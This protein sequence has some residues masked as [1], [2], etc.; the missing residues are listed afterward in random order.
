MAVIKPNYRQ[1]KKQ[2]ELARKTRQA[3]KQKRREARTTPETPD[4]A[5]APLPS[6]TDAGLP[7]KP[8][9]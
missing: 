6:P 4:M 5:E 2:K 3:Q 9:S 7:G 8:V 1:Q